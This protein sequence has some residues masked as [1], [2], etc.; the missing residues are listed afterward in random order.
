MTTPPGSSGAEACPVCGGVHLSA[1]LHR[2]QVPVHQNLVLHERG[3]A[4]SVMRGELDLVVCEDCGFVFN[5]AFDLSR[6]AYG[7]DYDNTQSCSACFDAYLDGLVQDLVER[8]GVR[9]STIVEV[10]CGKGHFLRKLV[11][12]PNSGN[13]GIGFDPSYVGPDIEE[14]GRVQFRRR[15]Y[16]QTCTEV[17]ADVVVCRHVIEHVPAPLALLRSVRAALERTPDARV[18]FETPCV[19]WILRH[20]VVWDFFYEHCSLFSAASLRLAFERTGFQVA[21]VEHIFGGQYLWLE[22]R[23]VEDGSHAPAPIQDTALRARA[24]GQDEQALRRSWLSRLEELKA[25]GRVALWGA[26]AKG[27]TFANL[28]DPDC[29]LIDCVVDL[30]PNKQGGYVPGT[31]HPIVAPADLPRRGVKSAVLMNPNYRD[32]NLRLLAEAGIELDLIDW[33]E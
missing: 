26:G 13:T 24:Y 22:A 23:A 3:A 33:S 10:G 16:D 4:R 15:Y 20:R 28:V 2:S 17:P 31:G 21:R 25:S 7:E 1:F 11:S 12:Y 19:E 5:R 9:D 29:A 30:N 6:L 18:F 14:D 32:E 27:A 8:Q